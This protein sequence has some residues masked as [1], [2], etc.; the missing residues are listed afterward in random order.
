MTN[1][2]WKSIADSAPTLADLKR[3]PLERQI[4]LLLARL[5]AM[6]SWTASVG[7]FNRSNLKL[8][9]SDLAIGYSPQ[10]QGPVI[11]YPLGWPWTEL[12]NRGY[13]VERDT[14]FYQ[15]S[16][17]GTAALSSTSPLLVSRAALEAVA[18][19][20]PDLAEAQLDFREGKIQGCC[21]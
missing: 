2:A 11:E 4:V 20:H 17:E 7:G 6:S 1:P 10:E 18:L 14:G 5:N 19:L 12:I 16:E 21:S 15:I 9:S 8:P 3:L 13:L